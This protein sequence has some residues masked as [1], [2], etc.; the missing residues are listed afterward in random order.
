MYS[1]SIF[2]DGNLDFLDD[3]V[4]GID[5]CNHGR[6]MHYQEKWDHYDKGYQSIPCDHLIAVQ[7]AKYQ[8]NK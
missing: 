6:E 5:W 2:T 8:G 4:K 7:T 3:E 1:R